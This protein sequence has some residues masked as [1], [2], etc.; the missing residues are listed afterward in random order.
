MAEEVFRIVGTLR[1]RGITVLLVEQN[2]S[3][4]LEL[5]D[6]AYVIENGRIVLSGEGRRLSE[7]DYVKRAYL[8]I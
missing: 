5:A 6:Y 2:V 7:D 3:R 4:T 1:D 8:G